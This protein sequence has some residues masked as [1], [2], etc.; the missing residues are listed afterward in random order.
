MTVSTFKEQLEEKDVL[1]GML[2]EDVKIL[3]I[4]IESYKERFGV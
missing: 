1:I 4:L 3:N 2:R